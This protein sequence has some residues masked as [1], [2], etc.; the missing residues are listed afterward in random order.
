MRSMSG[1][2]LLEEP[3]QAEPW[4]SWKPGLREFRPHLSPAWFGSATYAFTQLVPAA[5]TRVCP[6]PSPTAGQP[7]P[8]PSHP[9]T[10]SLWAFPVQPLGLCSGGVL[11][12][13][14]LLSL[15][16]VTGTHAYRLRTRTT[17]SRNS[18]LSPSTGLSNL[19]LCSQG[20]MTLCLTGALKVTSCVHRAKSSGG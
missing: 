12:P 11:F 14:P 2:L 17:S 20:P 7:C 1:G 8:A 18:S 6:L 19:P 4:H 9:T 3:E 15:F 16:L 10:G 5:R 13:G